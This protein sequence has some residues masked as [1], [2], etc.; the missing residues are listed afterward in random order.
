MSTVCI[1]D[2]N[3]P[4]EI[5]LSNWVIKDRDYTIIATAKIFSTNELAFK[6]AE[7]DTQCPEYPYYKASRFAIAQEDLVKLTEHEEVLVETFIE[8]LV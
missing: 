8:E 5:K 1:N 6:L 3:K 7:V 2:S 4:N